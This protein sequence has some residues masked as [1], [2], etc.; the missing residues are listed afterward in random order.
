MNKKVNT[1]L[2]VFGATFL[3]VVLMIVMFLAAF[4]AYGIFAA[5]RLPPGAHTIVVIVLFVLSIVGTYL[6]YHKLVA[7]MS[8]KVE[9]EKYF[10]PIFRPRKK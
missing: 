1:L 5:P 10:D 8:K 3:N 9:F 6:I 4:I 2:F 7:F